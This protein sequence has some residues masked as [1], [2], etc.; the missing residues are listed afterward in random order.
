MFSPQKKAEDPLKG[1]SA[2]KKSTWLPTGRYL[3]VYENGIHNF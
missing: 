3:H 2:F 1:H